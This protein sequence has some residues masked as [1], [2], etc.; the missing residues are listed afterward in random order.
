MDAEAKACQIIQ[1]EVLKGLP[2]EGP[3]PKHFHLG[4]PTPWSEGRVLRFRNVDG[5]GWVGNFQVC[6][7]G[8]TEVA[9]WPEAKAVVVILAG[10]LYLIDSNDPGNYVTLGPQC[11]V[12][13]TVL[14]KDRTKLFVAERYGVLAFGRD[15]T[16]IWRSE[17]LG[18]EIISIGDVDGV[19]E[20]DVEP[21]L[22]EPTETVRLSQEDGRYLGAAHPNFIL[23]LKPW[24]GL[25]AGSKSAKFFEDEL[26]RELASS[27]SLYGHRVYAVAKNSTRDDVLFRLEDGTFG[28]VHLTFTKT[29]PEAIGWPRSRMFESLADWMI[30]S[31]LPEHSE[32]FGLFLRQE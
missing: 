18:G 20:V 4:H 13:G 9:E 3:I 16:L 30:R 32:H 11:S 25:P 29:P 12:S 31:M 19:L 10:A 24:V 21:E 1:W 22:G 26:I 5:S 28:E 27:H 14:S 8:N 7:Y 6:G 2:G 15:R 17:G 23:F